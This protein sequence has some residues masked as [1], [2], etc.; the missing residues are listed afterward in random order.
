MCRLGNI[1][2][3]ADIIAQITFSENICRWSYLARIV[4]NLLDFLTFRELQATVL[5]FVQ[6]LI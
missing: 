2:T 6:V 5:A 3:A 1:L 4:S